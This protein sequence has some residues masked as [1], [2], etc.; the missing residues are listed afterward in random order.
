M[1]RRR[2][3]SL[4]Q[5]FTQY[6][7]IT[8][9]S[10]TTLVDCRLC[11]DIV[12]KDLVTA[13]QV[14]WKLELIWGCSLVE[15]VTDRIR[16]LH[17]SSVAAF[18]I[19]RPTHPAASSH[20]V[21]VEVVLPVPVVSMRSYRLD[22]VRMVIGKLADSGSKIRQRLTRTASCTSPVSI[23]IYYLFSHGTMED[24]QVRRTRQCRND[25]CT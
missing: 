9:R 10:Y 11:S 20:Q 25:P 19:K 23:M 17:L 6:L 21:P 14:A 5:C 16:I 22:Q 1:P 7:Y 13:I 15:V 18:I 24:K 8:P 3:S 2:T 12:R 4:C